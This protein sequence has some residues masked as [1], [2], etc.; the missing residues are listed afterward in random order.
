MQQEGEI[1]VK[2]LNISKKKFFLFNFTV[3]FSSN[4][5]IKSQK[6]PTICHLESFWRF[7]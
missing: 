3:W 4:I 7:D 1:I 2:N 6:I 5:K